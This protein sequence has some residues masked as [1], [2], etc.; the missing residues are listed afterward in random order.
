MLCHDGFEM[1]VRFMEDASPG[2]LY[3]LGELDYRKFLLASLTSWG[4]DL[5]EDIPICGSYGAQRVIDIALFQCI[6]SDAFTDFDPEAFLKVRSAFHVCFQTLYPSSQMIETLE[7]L[8]V[9]KPYHP[10]LPSAL[11]PIPY[12]FSRRKPSGKRSGLHQ[13]GHGQKSVI[14]YWE[15]DT[16]KEYFHDFRTVNFKGAMKM[17]ERSKFEMWDEKWKRPSD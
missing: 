2:S 10:R 14:W 4:Y 5:F 9:V 3:R 6:A 12:T 11:A 16:E 7:R 17:Y 8:K 13:L 15:F 1:L